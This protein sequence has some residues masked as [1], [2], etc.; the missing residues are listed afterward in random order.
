MTAPLKFRNGAKRKARRGASVFEA[1]GSQRR[2]VLITGGA[3]FIGSNLA[4]RLLSSGYPVLILDNLSRRGVEKNVAWLAGKHGSLLKVE[5]RDV[6]NSA[7]VHL[8]VRE[9]AAV[10]HFAAQVAVTDSLVDPRR[11]FEI[12]A[13]GTLNVL[14]ALRSL[15]APVPL[16]FTST[17]KVYGALADLELEANQLEYK[18]TAAGRFR[19]GISEDRAL[20]FESPYGCSKG[21]ADQY[22]CDY[23]RSFRLPAAV[24]RMSCIYGPHQFGTEDQGWVAHFLIQAAQKL[25]ITIYGDGKQVRDLLFIDDLVNAFLLAVDHIERISGQAFNIG[26]GPANALSLLQVIDWIGHLDGELP[27]IRMDAWR[28]GDQR[29]YVSDT[30]KFRQATGWRPETNARDGIAKLHRWLEESGCTSLQKPSAHERTRIS[31]VRA[32]VV[33]PTRAAAS[34][35]TST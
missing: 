15:C 12:N 16:L 22:V 23:A 4:N 35:T 18:L 9:A 1:N 2:P 13:L 19:N 7:A 11:D 33:H 21:A 34:A 28:Q 14:E 3:G 29:Y 6:R 17:N 8:A 20:D 32:P 31:A 26:G 27:S 24:F 25:P 5:E 10:F 30:S